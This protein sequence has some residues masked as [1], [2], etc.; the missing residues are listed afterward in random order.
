MGHK[1]TGS[2][3][4]Q[5]GSAFHDVIILFIHPV[6]FCLISRAGLESCCYFPR[7]RVNDSAEG[8][9]NENEKGP[10]REQLQPAFVDPI[11]SQ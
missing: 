11:R 4:M 6:P 1:A 8:E 7:R 3:S 5:R 10:K 2:L 9:K